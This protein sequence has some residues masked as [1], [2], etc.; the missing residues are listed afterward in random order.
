MQPADFDYVRHQEQQE[1]IL[2]VL[3]ANMI[4][5]SSTLDDDH[6]GL[7]LVVWLDGISP[8]IDVNNGN[9]GMGESAPAYKLDLKGGWESSI[10]R[11]HLQAW[12]LMVPQ[13]HQIFIGTMNDD[14]IGMY[15]YGGIGWNFVMNTKMA[16][17]E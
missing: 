11:V 7:Y 17:L 8:Y 14:Y 5:L 6:V 2:T 1:F 3:L 13:S 12:F 16:I 4:W 10:H 15:G 9:V